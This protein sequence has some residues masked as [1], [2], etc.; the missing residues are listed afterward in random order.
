METSL[1]TGSLVAAAHVLR[2]MQQTRP[3]VLLGPEAGS[4][5]WIKVKSLIRLPSK[6]LVFKM[7]IQLYH[8]IFS[9]KKDKSG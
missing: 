7:L 5:K 3:Y 1:K 9:I 2:Y 6:S 4:L 8:V